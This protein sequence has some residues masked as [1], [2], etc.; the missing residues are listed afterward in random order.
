[1]GNIIN[2]KE[3]NYNYIGNW[4]SNVYNNV[5]GKL[6]AYIPIYDI[7]YSLYIKKKG[8]IMI[9]YD[10]YSP[11]KPNEKVIFDIDIFFTKNIKKNN[12]AKSYYILNF[13]HKNNMGYEII[14]NIKK[15]D[16]L[17]Y[18]IGNYKSKQ[19]FDTG[20]FNLNICNH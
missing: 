17:D 2:K 18:I 11:H 3:I 4:K 1:M 6:Y 13:S 12:M 5:F 15:F 10:N 9:K 8:K 7:D 14:Y 19:P 16:N 20:L